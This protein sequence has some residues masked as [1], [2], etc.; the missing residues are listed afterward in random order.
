MNGEDNN[1]TFPGQAAG[2]VY[3]AALVNVSSTQASGDYFLH[4]FDGAIAGNGFYSRIFIKDPG[5][6]TNYAFGVQ[7]KSTVDAVYTPGFTFTPGTTHLVVVKYV[8]PSATNDVVQLFVD[9]AIQKP[10]P[11]PTLTA[12]HDI[13]QTDAVNMDGVAVRAAPA[14]PALPPLTASGSPPAGPTRSVRRSPPRPF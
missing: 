10:E 11:A 9:P 6:G 14:Q 8:R 13:T 2:T 7:F 1:H 5:T 3:M 12:V 4:M